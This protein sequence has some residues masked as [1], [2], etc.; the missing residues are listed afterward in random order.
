[1]PTQ[2]IQKH[3]KLL[4]VA[5]V[6][7]VIGAA[8]AATVLASNIVLVSR[9]IIISQG[10][11]RLYLAGPP[12]MWEQFLVFSWMMFVGFLVPA[13][14]LGCFIIFLFKRGYFESAV[15]AWSKKTAFILIGI[16][17]IGMLGPI[18]GDAYGRMGITL[19]PTILGSVKLIPVVV[20]AV[21]SM[22]KFVQQCKSVILLK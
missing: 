6:T 18:A 12:N 8:V 19:A 11:D 9:Y 16:V 5:I 4:V 7:G 14:I 1:M 22:V 17:C 3:F 13:F 21:Y 20:L 10:I 2:R 15:W